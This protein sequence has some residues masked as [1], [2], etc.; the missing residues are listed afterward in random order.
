MGE[1]IK[2]WIQL[3][4]NELKTDFIEICLLL[5]MS[6]AMFLQIT[7]ITDDKN[8]MLRG[9]ILV[10]VLTLILKI[11]SDSKNTEWQQRKHNKDIVDSYHDQFLSPQKRPE[12]ENLIA[13]MRAIAQECEAIEE[14][15]SCIKCSK[16]LRIVDGNLC[17]GNKWDNAS[18][19]FEEWTDELKRKWNKF[20]AIYNETRPLQFKEKKKF[21]DPYEFRD[22]SIYVISNFC[23]EYEKVGKYENMGIVDKEFLS[24]FFY[25]YFADTYLLC[26]PFIKAQRE[27]KA[28]Y[29]QHFERLTKAFPRV[30]KN[31]FGRN[32]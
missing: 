31:P 20:M 29:A 5:G 27:V 26:W 11:I 19:L 10:G 17:C 23:D 15:A 7:T 21:I 18:Q 16:D 22:Y 1:K 30:S 32:L 6:V 9:S 14:I 4:K 2:S 12:R 3:R 13:I 24:K 28:M 25:T 8:N